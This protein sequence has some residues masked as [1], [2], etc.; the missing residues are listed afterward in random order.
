MSA[1]PSAYN[2][3]EL[4]WYDDRDDAIA[5]GIGNFITRIKEWSACGQIGTISE[6]S[7]T[8]KLSRCVWT[9]KISRCVWTEKISQCVWTKRFRGAWMERVARCVVD[10]DCVSQSRQTDRASG[11]VKVLEPIHE[12][13]QVRRRFHDAIPQQHSLIRRLVIGPS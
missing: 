5:P 4:R 9:D 8:E 3:N 13:A 6:G 2:T 11:R 1:L 7:R 12:N 10:T